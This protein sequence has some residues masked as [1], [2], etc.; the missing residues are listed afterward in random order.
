MRKWKRD[1]AAETDSRESIHMIC[2]HI[3]CMSA[4][5]AHIIGTA[6]H[7]LQ[8][9]NRFPLLEAIMHGCDSALIQQ[10]AEDDVE[11]ALDNM[12]MKEFDMKVFYISEKSHRRSS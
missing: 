6:I 4:D 9:E 1:S 2:R 11:T 8:V 5:A 12:T 3:V 7:I 10:D